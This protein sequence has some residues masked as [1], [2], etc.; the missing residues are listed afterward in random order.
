MDFTTLATLFGS[1]GFIAAATILAALLFTILSTGSFHILRQRLWQL[2]SGKRKISDEMVLKYEQEQGDL[3]S[4]RTVSGLNVASLEEAKA[5]ATFA[6]DHGLSMELL[7][8]AGPHFDTKSL[9]LRSE[10]IPAQK[11]QWISYVWGS[12][13]ALIASLSLALSFSESAI[14]EF[15][16]SGIRIRSVHRQGQCHWILER[17]LYT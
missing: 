16:D 10:K 12:V 7:A 15:R 5:V 13:L 4:F 3:M 8:A 11:W 14:L 2:A 1:V 6:K 17:A 9:T